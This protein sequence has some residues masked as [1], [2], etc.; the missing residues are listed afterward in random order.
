MRSRDSIFTRLAKFSLAPLGRQERFRAGK[1]AHV[2][3]H[4]R[5]RSDVARGFSGTLVPAEARIKAKGAGLLGASDEPT[6]PKVSCMGKVKQTDKKGS[7]KQAARR[8]RSF[9]DPP[10]EPSSPRKKGHSQLTALLGRRRKVL[11][12]P[13]RAAAD[14]AAAADRPGLG[15]VRRLS[16]RRNALA[17]FDWRSLA[18]DEDHSVECSASWDDVDCGGPAAE[19]QPREEVNLWQRR[20]IVRPP[21]LQLNKS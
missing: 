1:D 17:D 9:G 13:V 20:T 7:S 21:E 8:T 14:S 16:S 19:L 12:P 11:A 10:P 18:D 2:G 6:S 4:S 15:Q 5:L 3:T